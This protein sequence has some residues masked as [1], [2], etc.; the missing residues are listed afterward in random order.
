MIAVA[1]AEASKIADDVDGV[2]EAT[3]K[4]MIDAAKDIMRDY[5]LEELPG[6][7]EKTRKSLRDAGYKSI[8]K[9]ANADATDLATS[10]D[11][12]GEATAKKIIAAAKKMSK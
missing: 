7:G 4:K 1:D 12:V 3:A 5:N 11:G 10:V 9:I 6:V 8:S 2:G